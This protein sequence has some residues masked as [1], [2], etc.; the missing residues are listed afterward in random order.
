M[1]TLTHSEMDLSINAKLVDAAGNPDKS[2]ARA[3][4]LL[5]I[6]YSYPPKEEPRAIQVSRLLKHLNA[7]TVLICEGKDGVTQNS[8]SEAES[9][10][11]KTLRVP[12]SPSSG[13]HLL[14]RVSS[15]IYLPV[16]L[17]TPDHLGTWKKSV[18]NTVDRLL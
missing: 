2:T 18:L 11:E 5:A 17:K 7:S 9:F 1:S 6:S 10:L 15:R 14:N 12:F 16:V 3:P 8:N 13:R 4:K